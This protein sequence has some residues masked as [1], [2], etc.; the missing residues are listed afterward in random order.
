MSEENY[1]QVFQVG[2]PA[3]LDLYNLRGTVQAVPM[4]STADTRAIIVKAV[5]DLDSGD[6]ELTQI[7]MEQREDG[8]VVIKTR[9]AGQDF[10][11][12]Q[13]LKR[14][15]CKIHYTVQVPKNCRVK[16]ETVSSSIELEKLEGE[17]EI[18][19]V[20][21]DLRLRNLLGVL[22]ARSVSGK[23]IGEALNGQAD[24]ENV[25]GDIRLTHS[26][27]PALKAKTVS[28]EITIEAAGQTETYNFHTISGDLTLIL[29]EDQGV[30]I[31]M[32][33]LSGKLNLHHPEG[34]TRQAAPKDLS[35]QGGGPKVRFETISGDLHLTT[36]E[37]HE[38][39]AAEPQDPGANQHD[40]LASVARGELSAEEGLQAL[41]GSSPD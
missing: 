14:R 16:I 29:A 27:I 13:Q 11:G 20:S 25:S 9:F 38:A 28:G 5:K 23:L 36:P 41:K 24:C 40:V 3:A 17:F 7:E 12:F 8:S 1:E 21:G 26:H 18:G 39:E 15:P 22:N 30:S 33:S 37:I 6:G 34:T 10:P 19:S 35:V 31:H 4:D 32:Q 2:E